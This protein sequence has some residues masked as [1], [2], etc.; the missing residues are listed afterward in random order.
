M[1]IVAISDSR[2]VPITEDLTTEELRLSVTRGLETMYRADSPLATPDTVLGLGEWAVLNADGKAERAGAVPVGHCYLVFA[3]TDRFDVK[4]TGKVTLIRSWP[5]NAK[6]NRYDDTQTYAVGDILTVKDL[7]GGESVVT[8]AAAG[9]A[10]LARVIWVGNG[11]LEF[12]T[13]GGGFAAP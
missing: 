12:E 6:T 2:T 9:E 1:G 13:L 8:K 4:A 11:W 3:G 7:G 5:I 10:A